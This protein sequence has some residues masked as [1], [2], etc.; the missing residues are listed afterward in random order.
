[1]QADFINDYFVQYLTELGGITKVYAIFG[2]DDFKSNYELL[3]GRNIP[4]V[5]FLDN[6]VVQVPGQDLYV[7]GYPYVGVAP[8]LH[9]DWEKWDKVPS[10]M[11]HKVYRT[12]GYISAD[13]VH[14]AVDLATRTATIGEDLNQLAAQSDPR[15]TIYVFHEAPYS[16]P[17]DMIASDNKYIKDDHLHIGSEAIREFI[18]REQPRATMH[19]HI[20]ETYDESGDFKWTTGDSI[21]MTAANDFSSDV[22]SYVMFDLER[23]KDAQRYAR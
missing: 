3:A 5:T 7:A 23:P 9:K 8:F 2:N 1:M 6:E 18:E 14:G 4:N 22:L 12:D 10:D 20:H 21:A 11:P 13:G 15:N 19:G 16:T 17:L